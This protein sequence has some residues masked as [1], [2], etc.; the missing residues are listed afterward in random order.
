MLVPFGTRVVDST[1]KSVGTVNR[2]ILHP[3]SREVAGLV[4]HQGVLNRR[5]VVVPLTKVAGAGDQVTLAVPG[6]ELAGFD[7][8]HSAALEPMPDH[9]DMPI[10]FDQ[11]DF[12]LVGTDAWADSVLPFEP[13]SAVTSRSPGYTQDP[14]AVA[15]PEEPDIVAGMPV[16][17]KDGQRV[18]DVE[19]VE[20]DET[21]RRIV[22]IT[23]R[24]G[25]LFAHETSIPASLVESITDRIVLRTGTEA[26]RKLGRSPS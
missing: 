24:R 13:T 16:Y 4:V 6:A 17:D 21:S 1:G 11:R 22:R 2:V 10:G 26:V 23:L 19:A 8:F 20:F 3:Q 15:E 14:G 9:W 7:L 5:E 25:F 12:F 18:G